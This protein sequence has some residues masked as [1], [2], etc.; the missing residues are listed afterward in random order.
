MKKCKVFGEDG[1]IYAEQLATFT[2]Y[3]KGVQFR[4][5]VTRLE[6]SNDVKVTHRY[7]GMSVCTVPHSTIA[8]C[9]NDYA[10]AGKST[11]DAL[12]KYKGDDRVYDVLRRAERMRYGLM[13]K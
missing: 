1:S 2:H 9:L 5:I 7:T 4:F 11:I 12:I 8:A 3:V 6:N 10:D 13:A